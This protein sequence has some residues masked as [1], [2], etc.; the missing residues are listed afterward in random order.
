[1]GKRGI[2]KRGSGGERRGG[3]GC[4]RIGRAAEE[5]EGEREKKYVY[6]APSNIVIYTSL[7]FSRASGIVFSA[8]LFLHV[9]TDT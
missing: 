2:S 6:V 5:R 3:V 7:F 9:D 4:F 8:L 1:M